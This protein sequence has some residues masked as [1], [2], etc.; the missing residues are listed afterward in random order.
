MHEA[1]EVQVAFPY[2]PNHGGPCRE[3]VRLEDK[4]APCGGWEAAVFFRNGCD[5]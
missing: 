4:E 3:S 5:H 1:L 2:S